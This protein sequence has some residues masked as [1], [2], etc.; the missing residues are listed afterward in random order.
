MRPTTIIFDMDD[1]LC[2]YDLGKR[3]RALSRLTGQTPRDIR[4][5]VWDS[6][7]EDEADTGGYPDPDSYLAEFGKRAGTRLTRTDWVAARR[8]SM[9]PWPEM[10]ALARTLGGQARL[11]LYTNNGPLAKAELG[12]LFPDVVEIFPERYFSFELGI[13]KPDPA[14]Y[15][16]VAA[17][18]DVNPEDCWFI[19]DKKSNV[20]GARMAGMLGHHFRSREKLVDDAQG[21]G[22][23]T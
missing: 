7:F 20:V 22:F 21:L 5:A 12:N 19:D 13:K 1:V 18:M 4:A 23:S 3:L 8:E 11:A 15:G 10:L 9:T 14:S 17:Q 6:G 2:R 16:K